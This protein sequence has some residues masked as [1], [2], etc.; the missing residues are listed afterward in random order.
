M[1]V[2]YLHA[3]DSH[4]ATV[5]VPMTFFI[6]LSIAFAL[7]FVGTRSRTDALASALFAGLATSAKYN[8]AL[9]ILGLAVAATHDLRRRPAEAWRRAAVTLLLAGLVMV[10]AFALTSPYAAL[11]WQGVVQGLVRQRRVLFGGPGVPAWRIHLLETLPGA[12]GW[13]GFVA[14]IVGLLRAI[15]KRRPSDLVLLAF[16]VPV[17]ASMAGMTWVLPRYPLLLVPPLAM[18]AAEA[19]LSLPGRRAVWLVAA[20]VLLVLPP[21]ATSSPTIVS[22]RARTRASWLPTGSRRTSLRGPQSPCA[23][24]T[25][26]QP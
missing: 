15:W 1:G 22:R 9:V 6:T 2:N 7:R 19:T 23:R 5:D 16:V 8:A 26:L 20:G 17:F 24:A 13:P 18:L 10:L 21:S 4:F 3:R 25:A 12:F 14:V 11:Q